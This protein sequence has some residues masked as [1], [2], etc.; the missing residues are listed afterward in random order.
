MDKVIL[1][2]ILLAIASCQISYYIGFA[3][4]LKR[5]KDIDDKIIE[6]ILKK[7]NIEK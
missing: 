7:Y 6:D 2:I 1:L 3:K 4:G 5:S